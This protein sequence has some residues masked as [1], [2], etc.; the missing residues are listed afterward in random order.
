M[1]GLNTRAV[2]WG[3]KTS[4]TVGIATFTLADLVL[5]SA[6]FL[7][8]PQL[9]HTIPFLAIGPLH[10]AAFVRVTHN[11]SRQAVTHYRRIY[12][13]LYL[14]AGALSVILAWS[15]GTP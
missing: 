5:L 9:R 3:V 14:L 6:I 7:S 8:W 10:G 2:Q 15:H 4:L 11:P 1:A 12:R 13:Q